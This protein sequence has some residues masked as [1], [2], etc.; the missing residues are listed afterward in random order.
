MISL[1]LE[2]LSRAHR[3][4]IE[5]FETQVDLKDYLKHFALR[6]H[7]RDHLSRTWVATDGQR[8][9]G[10]FSLAACSIERDAVVGIN[11]LNRLPRF[12]I[13]GV[14]LA[15]LAVDQRIQARVW[16]NGCLE[17]RFRKR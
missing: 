17:R 11:S 6:H 15:R 14:L 13:P 3:S 1:R 4:Q 12:P 10:Y 9:A 5:S 16:E 8:L 7:E 2:P